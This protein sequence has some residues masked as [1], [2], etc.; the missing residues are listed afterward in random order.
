MTILA[1]DDAKA[2]L[3]VFVTDD[4]TLIQNKIA[5]AEAWIGQ[6]IGQDLNT[7]S[8]FPD[9]LKEAIRQLVA[10]LYNN[11]EASLIGIN[12]VD[13]CPGLFDLLAPYRTWNF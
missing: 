4:D 9:P 12:I 10:H 1:L 13:N 8:P 2:H 7:L 5:A 11:R 3:N 6:Y